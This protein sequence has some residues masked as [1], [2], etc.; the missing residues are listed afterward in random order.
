MHLFFSAVFIY[1]RKGSLENV[2]IMLLK[3]LQW[4]AGLG[5]SLASSEA[6]LIFNSG[7]IWNTFDSTVL[8]A[9]SLLILLLECYSL[10]FFHGWLLP[11]IQM[12]IS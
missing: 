2:K 8:Q 1:Y 7:P 12:C 11:M 4:V 9:L 6:I 10:I 5:P 3:I